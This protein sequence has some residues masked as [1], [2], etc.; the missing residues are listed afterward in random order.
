MRVVLVVQTCDNPAELGQDY[1]QDA[2]EIKISSAS[3]LQQ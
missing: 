3:L 2:G 1:M